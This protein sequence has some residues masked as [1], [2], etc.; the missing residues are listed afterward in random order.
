[1]LANKCREARPLD[2]TPPAGQLQRN[3]PDSYAPIRAPDDK[4]YSV[5][6]TFPALL[7]GSDSD[8]L[9]QACLTQFHFRAK[10]L[11]RLARYLQYAI[12]GG[13]EGEQTHHDGSAPL[14]VEL[15]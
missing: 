4:Q 6:E 13:P 3:K 5:E 7:P 1:M 14:A 12:V 11:H 15:E 10:S 2:S 8:N 9:I